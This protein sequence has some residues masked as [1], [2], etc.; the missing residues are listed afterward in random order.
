MS[1]FIYVVDAYVVNVNFVVVLGV[2]NIITFVYAVISVATDGVCFAVGM[3]VAVAVQ[4]Q[5]LG[6]VVLIDV[7]T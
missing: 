4:L 7:F 3:V 1:I 6:A 2:V 5:I